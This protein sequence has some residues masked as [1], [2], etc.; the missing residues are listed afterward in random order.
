MTAREFQRWQI[1]AELEP[2]GPPRDDH[3]AGVV[4]AAAVSPWAKKG[5]AVTPSTFFP[6]LAGPGRVPT[7]EEQI[8]AARAWAAFARGSRPE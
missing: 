1:Y 4:A 7:V 3:R 6:E 8:A 2:F 5:D